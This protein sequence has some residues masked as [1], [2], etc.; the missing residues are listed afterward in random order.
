M[1][2]WVPGMGNSSDQITM[3]TF[4]WRGAEESLVNV[5]CKLFLQW[6]FYEQS[7]QEF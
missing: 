6:V 2:D 7:A 4:R 5:A 3:L 1:L